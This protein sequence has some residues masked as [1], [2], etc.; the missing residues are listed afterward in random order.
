MLLNRYEHDQL[1]FNANLKGAT[2]QAGLEAY[3]G[4]LVLEEGEIADAL[5][6]RKRP[7]RWSS[8][9]PCWPPPTS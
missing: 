6:R 3:R 2:T 5:G 7:T 8:K 4:D 9:W 1:L